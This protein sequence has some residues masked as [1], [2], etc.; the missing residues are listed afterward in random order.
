MRRATHWTFGGVAVA[1]GISAAITGGLYIG[2]RNDFDDAVRR[3]NDPNLSA[4]ERAEARADGLQFADRTD[5]LARASNTLFG[6]ACA[7]GIGAMVMWIVTRKRDKAAT[8]VSLQLSPS[9]AGLV[10]AGTF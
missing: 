7:L 2:S 3:S 8:D 4:I 10:W 9:R 5:A 6:S 1:T